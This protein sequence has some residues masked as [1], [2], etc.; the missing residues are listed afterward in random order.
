MAIEAVLY[1]LSSWFLIPVLVTIILAFVYALYELGRFLVEAG[2]RLVRTEP[3]CPVWKLKQAQPQLDSDHLELAILK[4]LE[5]LR[6]T[7]RTAPLLGLVATMIP[8]G[9]AL[10]GVSAGE[11][12]LVGEQVGIAFAAV[13]VALM[14]ASVC[15]I[16]LTV[17]RRWRLTSLKRIEDKARQSPTTAGATLAQ[18]AA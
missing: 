15:F 2:L 6:I 5:G 3:S 8:M 11:M 9:P 12:G 14:A 10:A 17:K 1:Q 7:A 18:E 4:E 16:L 13:I